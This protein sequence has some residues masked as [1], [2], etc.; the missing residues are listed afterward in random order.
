VT[1]V[2]LDGVQVGFDS[3]DESDPTHVGRYEWPAIAVAP[4]GSRAFVVS[5]GQIAAVDLRTL[6]VSY[7]RLGPARRRLQRVDKGALEGKS[8]VALWAGP[9][10]LLVTGSDETTSVAANGVP[11]GEPHPIGLQLVDTRDW[12]TKTID[13][14]TS[15]AVV[16]SNGILAMSFA[17]NAARQRAEGGGATIYSLTGEKRA[18]LFGRQSVGGMVVGRR[19]FVIGSSARYTIISTTTGKIVRRIDGYLPAP[20]LGAA[21]S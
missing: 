3:F 19:A 20:L 21:Q 6:Q 11:R 17:W 2:G 18:H 7:H 16:G 10:Q 4:D 8:R 9:D 15:Y 5:P 12:S 13:S 1:T 14:T